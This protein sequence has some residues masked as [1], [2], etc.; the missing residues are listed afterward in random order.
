[1]NLLEWSKGD[2]CQG[3][4]RGCGISRSMFLE[5]VVAGKTEDE[6]ETSSRCGYMW[7]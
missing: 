5:G 6:E 4:A 2:R 7:A 1:M 3:Q